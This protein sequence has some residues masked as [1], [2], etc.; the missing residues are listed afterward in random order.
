MIEYRQL[1]YLYTVHKYKNFTRASKELYVSQP[2]VSAGI[3]AL[4][5]E[6]GIPLIDRAAKGLVFTAEGERIVAYASKI[7][8]VYN[9]LLA[10]AKDMSKIQ[11]STIRLGIASILSEEIFPII[12]QRYLPV[13]P[14]ITIRLD[15]DS[16][17]DQI[18]KLI[19]G[20]LDLALNGLP[21]D[22]Q[23][24]K[25]IKMIPV[26]KREIKVIMHKDHPLAS[27]ESIPFC[28][29][30]GESVSVMSSAGVMGQLLTRAFSEQRLS[31]NVMSEHSQING[32]FEMLLTGCSIGFMNLDPAEKR[33]S[34]YDN[35][36]VRSLEEPLLFD[37]GFMMKKDRYQSSAC[38]DL[39]TYISSEMKKN[40]T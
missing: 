5:S 26:C 20:D 32:M 38:R 3:K 17:L 24:S 25:E 19:S 35:L 27:L 34:K 10:E 33:I 21:E 12:Y 31:L 11:D 23:F 16:A 18:Q 4:E 1:L 29:L 13:H 37:I 6:L 15:E 36:T 8:D 40:K 39:I 28:L 14:G 9:D 22:D 30:N 2:T 7:V